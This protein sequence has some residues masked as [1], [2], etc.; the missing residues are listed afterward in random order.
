MTNVLAAVEVE[1]TKVLFFGGMFLRIIVIFR[2]ILGYIQ[3]C[4]SVRKHTLFMSN[5]PY[6][7]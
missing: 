2:N 1:S 7:F 4:L 3:L 5:E 6:V